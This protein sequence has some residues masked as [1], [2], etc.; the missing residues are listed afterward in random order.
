MR[1]ATKPA[2]LGTMTVVLLHALARTRLSMRRLELDLSERGHRVVSLDYPSTR[3][4]LKSLALG[5]ADALEARGIPL[6][7]TTSFVGHS[8]G[9]VVY[10]AL[11]LVRPGLRTGPSVTVGS[12]LAGSAVA[13]TLA[14]LAAVRWFYGPAFV[15]LGERS[16][17]LLPGPTLSIAGTR[18]SPLVPAYWVLRA[19]GERRQSDSTVLVDEALAPDAFAH[20]RVAAAHTFL[21]SHPEVRSLVAR[22]L[23]DPA[24]F[25][26]NPARPLIGIF[27]GGKSSR[28][29]TTKG[30]IASPDGEA[31][32]VRLAR[33][34]ARFGEVV[35]VGD[36]SAV[37]DLVPG[38]RALE[39][40]PSGIGPIGG[41]AALLEAAK[42]R[43]VLA[44]ASDLPFADETSIAALLAAAPGAEV[45]AS[46]ADADAPYEPLFARYRPAFRTRVEAAIRDGER[47]LQRLLRAADSRFVIPSDPRAIRD[48]DTPEDVLADGGSPDRTR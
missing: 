42:G 43:D 16:L 3:K 32:I 46:R 21:P 48:W 35:L 40:T 44:L 45:V 19:I 36:A 8:M 27:V 12:P 34:A 24:S 15:G 23:I 30:R 22:F 25:E 31:L 10:R 37:R 38:L 6:D 41:L 1:V 13:R 9:G 39:D 11:S 47:S 26:P 17:P 33:I 28:M 2:I 7:E 5:V 4:D 18:A 20:A 14:E 29:G